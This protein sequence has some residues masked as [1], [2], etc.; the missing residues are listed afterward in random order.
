MTPREIL[1]STRT[2]AVFWANPRTSAP[3]YYVPAYL[4]GA[5][6]RVYPVHPAAVHQDK[7]LWGQ[8]MLQRLADVPEPID[9]I[10][11]FRRPEAIPDHVP[12]ILALDPLPKVVWFQSGIVNDVAA[13]ALRQAGITVVQ[14]RCT[15]ADH[16]SFGL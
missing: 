6:Y 8:P 15:L 3:A 1:V 12:E 16:R 4:A 11:V 9:L 7:T 5:G 14:D 2:I 13:A 10:D